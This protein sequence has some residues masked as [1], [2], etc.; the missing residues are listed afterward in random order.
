MRKTFLQRDT[1]YMLYHW[2]LLILIA[3]SDELWYVIN[4]QKL[5]REENK[6]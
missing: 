4:A 2:I 6:N 3:K 5:I 1:I